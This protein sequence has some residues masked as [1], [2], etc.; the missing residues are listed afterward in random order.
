MSKEDKSGIMQSVDPPIP[1]PLILFDGEC[2]FCTGS[3]LFVIH[4]DPKR[5]FRFV[6]MQSPLG[7]DLLRK[8]NLRTS[9]FETF[10]FLE[11][12]FFYT[13]STA[14]LRIAKGMSGFWPV[15]Y[16]F[17]VVPRPVRDFFYDGV[18]TRRYKLLGRK[19]SCFI[20]SRELRDRFIER[21]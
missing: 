20:P 7:Q 8:L 18:A 13:K 17:M 21:F 1:F 15:L 6:P 5:R 19:D 14:A 12:G 10:V 4:R 11:N 9:D 3:V 2:N 16:W